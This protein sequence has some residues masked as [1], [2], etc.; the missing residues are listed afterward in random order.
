MY[1]MEYKIFAIANNT[2]DITDILLTVVIVACGV[3]AIVIIM[4][5]WDALHNTKN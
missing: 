1:E 5:L 4:I 3:L 2:F